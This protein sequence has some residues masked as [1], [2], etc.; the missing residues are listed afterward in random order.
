LP[1]QESSSLRLSFKA[2]AFVLGQA[3]AHIQ[4]QGDSRGKVNILGD[5]TI[6]RWE[7]KKLM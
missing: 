4:V 5:D 7:K 6:S 1:L 3:V 2:F